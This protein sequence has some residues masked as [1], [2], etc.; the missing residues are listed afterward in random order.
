MR[1][2]Y[3]C[4]MCPAIHINS[5]SWLRSSSTHE[6]S[7]PPL[8]VVFP[9]SPL[10]GETWASSVRATKRTSTHRLC[11]QNGLRV[12][13]KGRPLAAYVPG[14][15]GPHGRNNEIG[16]LQC[17][18]DSPGGSTALNEDGR[19]WSASLNRRTEDRALPARDTSSRHRSIGRVPPRTSLG[20]GPRCEVGVAHSLAQ[21][22]YPASLVYVLSWRAPSG[23]S[24]ALRSPTW[25]EGE[26][27]AG[28][29][30]TGLGCARRTALPRHGPAAT[31]P[32]GIP[33]TC[34]YH[35]KH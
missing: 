1:S 28:T 16:G 19:L 13:K 6:P 25:T 23:R 31:D 12:A 3:R 10:V 5:R 18:A 21:D 34:W 35:H 7:D 20:P 4:S 30:D 24:R 15:E 11:T 22:R 14:H 8:R 26:P 33:W 29:A 27:R 2:R 9:F 17:G 32:G